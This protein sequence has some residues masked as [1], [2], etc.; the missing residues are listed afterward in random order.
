MKKLLFI[1]ALAACGN[2]SNRAVVMVQ[3]QVPKAKCVST[4]LGNLEIAKCDVPGK[5]KV[6][7]F[8]AIYGTELSQT[9]QVYPLEQEKK[10]EAPPAPTPPVAPTPDAGTK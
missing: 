7:P 8:I 2:E 3:A 9:F 4:I 1:V 10:P 6:V 5:D